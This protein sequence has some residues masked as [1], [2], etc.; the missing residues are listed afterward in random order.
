M[1]EF[2]KKLI[3]DI[4]S[5]FDLMISRKSLYD[6]HLRNSNDLAHA[7]LMNAGITDKNIRNGLIVVVA[8][9]AV[10]GASLAFDSM[11]KFPA[12]SLV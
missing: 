1:T 5:K 11:K 4:L 10:G 8:L 9:L 7:K 6:E 12:L 3:I 2:F